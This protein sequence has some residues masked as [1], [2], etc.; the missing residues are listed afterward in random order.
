MTRSHP[1]LTRCIRVSPVDVW[2]LPTEKP[3]KPRCA[4]VSLWVDAQEKG[5]LS[6][7]ADPVGGFLCN[8][9]VMSHVMYLMS[10]E[11]AERLVQLSS[12]Q[13]ETT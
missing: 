13:T 12:M 11:L 5:G 6:G 1:E 7:R 4:Y 10:R 2:I 8:L 3:K 9:R